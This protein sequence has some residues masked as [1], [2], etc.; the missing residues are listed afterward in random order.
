MDLPPDFR[1]E[2]TRA[3]DPRRALQGQRR[4]TQDPQREG[5]SGRPGPHSPAGRLPCMALCDSH[6][7]T[8]ITDAFHPLPNCPDTKSRKTGEPQGALLLP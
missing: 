2:Q 6:A 1:Q 5:A 8:R 3:G 4:L 7:L